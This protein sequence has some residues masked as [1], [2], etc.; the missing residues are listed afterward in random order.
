MPLIEAKPI[1]I[2][3]S[4]RALTVDKL[5]CDVR[6][7]KS[8]LD[9]RSSERLVHQFLASHSYF[10][11]GII[12]LYSCS[13][14]YSKIKLGECYELDFACI[15]I[16][17][18]GPEWQL[19][20]IESAKSTLF[21]KSGDQTSILTHA[22]RQAQDWHRWIHS[23]VPYAQRLLPQ[24]EYPICHVFVG[25]RKELTD[26]A[27]KRLRRLNYD[28]RQS[29]QVHTLDWFASA[30]QSVENLVA[31]DNGGN[32]P[33]R[34][35]ALKHKDL[36]KGLP[37]EVAQFFKPYEPGGCYENMKQ[38]HR[39]EREHLYDDDGGRDGKDFI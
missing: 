17:S 28:L 31:R 14:L 7:Y 27:A 29:I 35:K 5:R 3:P 30:A 23:N 2:D 18:F 21:R 32:W 11:N 1:P 10:F 25:R 33:L 8:L 22:I 12:R 16:S 6:E 36:A 26:G 9:S 4:V 19:V 24:V 20:E 39:K 13:P 34:M 15:D 38:L 37:S